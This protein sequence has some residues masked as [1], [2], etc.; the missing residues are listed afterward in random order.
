MTDARADLIKF[1]RG[2][3]DP[4]DFPHREHVRMAFEMLRSHSFAE[5]VLHYSIALR[6]MA[7]RAGTPE[8]YNET[9]TIAFLSVIA[10]CLDASTASDFEE[11]ERAHPELFDRQLL[12]R[13]YTPQRL[14]SEAAR[15]TFLLPEPAP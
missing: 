9:V 3:C 6:M 11:F 7:G 13:W 2:E 15:R 14:Q 8:A 10:E 4:A 5:T 1:A 12:A